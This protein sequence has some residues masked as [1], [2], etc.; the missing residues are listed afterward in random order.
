[1]W[2]ATTRP[3]PQGYRGHGFCQKGTVGI[4]GLIHSVFGI[5]NEAIDYLAIESGQILAVICHDVAV[6]ALI[7]Q[8]DVLLSSSK[9]L[10]LFIGCPL[11]VAGLPVCWPCRV[12]RYILMSMPI[13]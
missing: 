7:T 10:H 13:K 11:S 3:Q 4:Y 12:I 8:W 5:G 6:I 1:M 2:S 9:L